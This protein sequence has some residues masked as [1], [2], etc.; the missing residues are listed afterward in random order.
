MPVMDGWEFRTAQL[1][2]PS[3][4]DVPVIVVSAA[5]TGREID[6]SAFIAKPFAIDELLRTI[7]RHASSSA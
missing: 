7:S 4:A 5:G 2:D 6:A 1:A 3:I